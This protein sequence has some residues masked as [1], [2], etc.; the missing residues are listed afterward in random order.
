MQWQKKHHQWQMLTDVVQILLVANVNQI[1]VWSAFSGPE[2][3]LWRLQWEDYWLERLMSSAHVSKIHAI[4]FLDI[5]L[6]TESMCTQLISSERF[7]LEY[8]L[9]CQQEK[10]QHFIVT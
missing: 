4:D 9:A 10:Y 5:K 8:G 6:I 2:H 1:Q 7:S 3:T